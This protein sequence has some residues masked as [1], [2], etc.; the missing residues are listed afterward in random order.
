MDDRE[1]IKKIFG[2]ATEQKK[3]TVVPNQF[4]NKKEFAS[5][6]ASGTGAGIRIEVKQNVID[7]RMIITL[8]DRR[9]KETDGYKIL[10]DNIKYYST[11]MSVVKILFAIVSNIEDP[12]KIK[13][14]ISR[15]INTLFKT[16][17]DVSDMIAS[18]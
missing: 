1:I 3:T 6:K 18:R 7:Y 4:K 2:E 16:I 9:L 17:S 13:D 8:F 5:M 14:K 15:Y 10:K 12:K 11:F